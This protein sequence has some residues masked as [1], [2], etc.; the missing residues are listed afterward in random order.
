LYHGKY[1][2]ELRRKQPGIKRLFAVLENQHANV[3][4]AK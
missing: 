4:G 3:C 2:V 1:V